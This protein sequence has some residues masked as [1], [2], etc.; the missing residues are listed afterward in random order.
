MITVKFY[1][2]IPLEFMEQGTIALY[3]VGNQRE[4]FGFELC[5]DQRMN[6]TVDSY[7]VLIMF[8]FF[9]KSG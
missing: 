4:V 8:M 7:H 6:Y 3:T 9:K 5:W 2:S 1:V